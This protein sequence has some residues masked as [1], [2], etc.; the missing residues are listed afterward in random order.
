M[1]IIKGMT[2]GFSSFIVCI[3]A[4]SPTLFFSSVITAV[5]AGVPVKITY[6]STNTT[7]VSDLGM[8]RTHHGIN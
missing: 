2:F 1:L 3:H 6:S 5:T 8:S 7:Q 4:Q